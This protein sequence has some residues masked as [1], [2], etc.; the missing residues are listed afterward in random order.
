MKTRGLLLA[1]L[2]ALF[3]VAPSGAGEDARE[4]DRGLEVVD[5]QGKSVGNVIGFAADHALGEAITPVVSFRAAGHPIVV[6]AGVQGFAPV[7]AGWGFSAIHW[8]TPNCSG[9][10]YFGGDLPPSGFLPQTLLLGQR[11]FAVAGP[12]QQE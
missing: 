8:S 5:A 4:H 9:T 7:D 1:P 12:A 2:F 10:Q 3:L 6:L 11:V